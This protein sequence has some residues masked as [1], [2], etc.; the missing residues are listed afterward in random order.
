MNIDK[1]QNLNNIIIFKNRNM[2]ILSY[3]YRKIIIFIF[4]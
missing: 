1:N 2:S 3:N 4:Y